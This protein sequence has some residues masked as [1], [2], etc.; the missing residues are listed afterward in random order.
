VERIAVLL[1][2]PLGVG[3]A[4]RESQHAGHDAIPNDTEGLDR[5][6]VVIGV[7]QKAE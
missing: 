4:A 1:D 7:G 5:N 3:L 6:V 2:R